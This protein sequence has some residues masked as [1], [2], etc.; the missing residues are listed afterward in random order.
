MSLNPAPRNGYPYRQYKLDEHNKWHA[1][2][3][4]IVKEVEVMDHAKELRRAALAHAH[5]SEALEAQLQ[6]LIYQMERLAVELADTQL[7]AKTAFKEASR[8]QTLLWVQEEDSKN[9]EGRPLLRDLV[10]ID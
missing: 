9:P 2:D 8:L 7:S 10:Q 6:C 1:P 4:K 5:D 3:G